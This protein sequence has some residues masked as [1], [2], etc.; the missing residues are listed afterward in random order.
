MLFVTCG[1]ELEP[2]L[3]Q[4]LDALGYETRLGYRGVFVTDDSM[5]AIYRINYLS[6]I[7]TRVLL[8]LLQFNCRN[9]QNLYDAVSTID[10]T[11]YFPPNTSF[12]IDANVSN[13]PTL[14]NSLFASQ[15]VKDAICD[16][17][18]QNG[19][20]RPDVN[21]KHP[22]MRLN[23]FIQRTQATLSF[24]TSLN[25]LN[26]RGYRQS[27]SEAPLQ[28]SLAAALL[29]LAEY[30][31]SQVLYDPCAGSGTF[32]IEAAMIATKTP[33]GFFRREWGF[34]R[35]PQ[36]SKEKWLALKAEEDAK[37]IPLER[38]KIYGTESSVE[39]AKFCRSHLR[40]VGIV[41]EVFLST[42]DFQEFE[43]PVPPDFMISN[44]PHGRRLGDVGELK[45]LY[46]ALGDWMKRKMAKPAR[47]FIFT[48]SL[49][50]SKEVGL[51]PS[52]RHVIKQSNQ[53][54]RFL[55]FD[56]F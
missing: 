28:E 42:K 31:G 35:H 49:E 25:S 10:W 17:L 13:L 45:P 41:D 7:A 34:M 1:S 15:V 37:R 47:A 9:R 2:L 56:I 50:L 20:E 53:D 3:Q 22:K 54:A 29:Y 43:P 18:T 48:T 12:V 27:M 8:P 38:K 11:P 14:K 36:F 52:R 4:E 23:L 6:R 55:A 46:R 51:K 19:K 21:L 30:D 32:L 33:A 5:E 26:K 40:N 16:Q 39:Q 44:P 24:D